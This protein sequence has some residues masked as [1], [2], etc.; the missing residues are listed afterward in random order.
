MKRLWMSIGECQNY[1]FKNVGAPN[2]EILKFKVNTER[3]VGNQI[4][5][6]L[7]FIFNDKIK[8]KNLKF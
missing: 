7:N 5:L 8:E 4:K 1:I 3:E 6:H 2:F